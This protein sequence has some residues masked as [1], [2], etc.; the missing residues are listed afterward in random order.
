[1]SS[2]GMVNTDMGRTGAKA[3]GLKIKD[4]AITPL[5]SV[6]GILSVIHKA[7][8]ETHGGKFWSYTGKQMTY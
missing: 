7:T 2:P 6:T 3:F 5:E 4:I 1:M 8:K